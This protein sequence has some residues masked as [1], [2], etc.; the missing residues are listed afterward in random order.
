MKHVK[1]QLSI[2]SKAEYTCTRKIHFP[3]ARQVSNLTRVHACG[4]CCQKQPDFPPAT[5]GTELILSLELHSS[6]GP[7]SLITA[8]E[9]TLNFRLRPMTSAIIGSIPETGPRFYSK[10]SMYEWVPTSTLGLTVWV[11][12]EQDKWM[13]MDNACWR[14]VVTTASV[15][16]TSTSKPSIITEC[17]GYTP[18][19][20]IGINAT[21]SLQGG[22][23]Y[24]QPS[25]YRLWH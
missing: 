6:N 1:K 5:E 3:P 21:T 13:R 19:Q 2:K 11:I 24:T 16:T 8:Y 10:T 25:Q 18:D 23:A 12:L 7:V 15:S 14:S 9:P 22:K 4:G 17:P 20:V